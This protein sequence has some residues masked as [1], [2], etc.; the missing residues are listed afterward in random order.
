[1]CFFRSDAGWKSSLS[2]PPHHINL[3]GNPP[4]RQLVIVCP[5]KAERARKGPNKCQIHASNRRSTLCARNTAVYNGWNGSKV[6]APPEKKLCGERNWKE[7]Q[8]SEYIPGVIIYLPQSIWGISCCDIDPF[9]PSKALSILVSEP[10]E[11]TWSGVAP[12]R[13]YGCSKPAAP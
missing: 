13:G 7:Q 4:L 12:Y 2:Q 11:Y 5:S 8:H 1:M 3:R 10:T 9:K 6:A